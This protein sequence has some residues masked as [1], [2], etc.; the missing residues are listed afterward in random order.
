MRNF[1]TG[2]PRKLHPDSITRGKGPS[3]LK[4]YPR[5]L[6]VHIGFGLGLLAIFCPAIPINAAI[7]TVEELANAVNNGAANATIDIGPGTFNLTSPLQP[8]TG[9][10][11]RGAGAGITIITA[12][13]SWSPGAGGL[14]EGPVDLNSVD[15]NAYLFNLGSGPKSVT[16]SDMTLKG[17]QHRGA[18]FGNACD[19][20]NLFNLHIENFLWSAIRLFSMRGANIHDNVLLNAGGMYK[21]ETAGAIFVAWI[22]NSQIWKWGYPLDSALRNM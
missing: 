2:Y 17:P 22:R 21:N 13:S 16:I 5:S 11:I 9:M 14:P 1:C 7:T 15:R 3:V 12:A 6:A 8:K 19:S 10:I 20:L 18:I 4:R